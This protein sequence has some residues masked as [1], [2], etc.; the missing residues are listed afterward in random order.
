MSKDWSLEDW[1]VIASAAHK[2][3]MWRR[4]AAEADTP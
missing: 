2:A 1:A 4:L 3:A